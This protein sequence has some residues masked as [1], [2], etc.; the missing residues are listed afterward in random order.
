MLLPTF[1]LDNSDD[2]G[3]VRQENDEDRKSI[4]HSPVEC[5]QDFIIDEIT[6]GV[7][8]EIRCEIPLSSI[9]RIEKNENRVENNRIDQTQEKR[10]IVEHNTTLD[11]LE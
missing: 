1:L 8:T 9:A 6:I 11:D 7:A 10:K 4:V 2:Q 3:N 5:T